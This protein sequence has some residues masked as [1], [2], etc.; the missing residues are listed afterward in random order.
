[1]KFCACGKGCSD[2]QSLIRCNNTCRPVKSGKASF[3]QVSIAADKRSLDMKDL[4]SSGLLGLDNGANKCDSSISNLGTGLQSAA[5]CSIPVDRVSCVDGE[6]RWSENRNPSFFGKVD[7]GSVISLGSLTVPTLHAQKKAPSGECATP[8][9]RGFHNLSLRVISPVEAKFTLLTTSAYSEGTKSD[10]QNSN[11]PINLDNKVPDCTE[12]SVGSTTFPGHSSINFSAPCP[13]YCDAHSSSGSEAFEDLLTRLRTDEP[14]K[15][16]RSKGHSDFSFVVSDG[17]SSS[18]LDSNDGPSFYHRIDNTNLRESMNAR[19]TIPVRNK[20]RFDSSS[21]SSDGEVGKSSALELSEG[22]EFDQH[23]QVDL[24]PPP[25]VDFPRRSRPQGA[26]KAP[27]F[28]AIENVQQVNAPTLPFIYSLSLVDRMSPSQ[29]PVRR[30][31]PSA[32]RFVNN[33][34]KNRE[35]LANR[36]L[37]YFNEVIFENQLPGELRVVWNERLLKTAGQCVYLKRNIKHADGSVT[38]RRE[39][40]IELSGK[41]CT[42]AER[43]RDTLLHEACHAAVWLV[44][45]VND[46][47]G[48]LWRAFVRRANSTFPHLPPVTVRHTYAIDTRFTYRCTGCFATINRHSKSLDIQKKVCGRCQS[49]F[50][51]FVNKSGEI[52]PIASAGGNEAKATG[53]GSR[54]RPVFADFVKVHYRER[55]EVRIELSGKVCTSAERVR[56]TLL[57]EAC[58][59]AV[60][61]VHGVNDGH[62]RLWRAFVRRANSTFPH[63]P[64]VTVRHTYAI[65]TR[66][67]YR[68]TGCFAT[69]NRHSKSLDIQKKV[70]GRCQSQFQLFVNKSGE[71][72]PI[73]SAGGNEA[74]ATGVGSRS[75]PVFADFVKV[76]YREAFLMWRRSQLLA[77]E[78]L[79]RVPSACLVLGFPLNKHLTTGCN[80]GLKPDRVAELK[81][82]MRYGP[83][84]GDFIKSSGSL[85]QPYHGGCASQIDHAPNGRYVDF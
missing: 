63:L 7:C 27:H 38:S 32:E 53:V 69:I 29:T 3:T 78:A 84:L 49:Q 23:R 12:N 62:G 9:C 80:D 52:A 57:H 16:V 30:R 77:R 73:A 14:T 47:H 37:T 20:L 50:Q 18:D 15:Q 58:H 1:M 41:V 75:R 59:A 44:H 36:L 21:D 61:L 45:G 2:I 17:S 71:I 19:R 72:A 13:L 66:F 24:S 83:R 65:D 46:G 43:V 34:K 64:P 68:C 4:V 70:C 81:E 26:E 79:F 8:H 74:K 33:F 51:L 67:T 60:W 35:E 39:V 22:D 6:R 48:R 31:H 42:S 54:S 55:R 11:E 85:G 28:N 40:R 10:A 25:I 5:E 82:R 56:D 76:H